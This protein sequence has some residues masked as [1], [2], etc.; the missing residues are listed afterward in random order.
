MTESAVEDTVLWSTLTKLYEYF[1]GWKFLVPFV[2]AVG[3]FNHSEHCK[4]F[5]I[6]EWAHSAAD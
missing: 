5:V 2:L 6:N 4:V 3:L 1:G